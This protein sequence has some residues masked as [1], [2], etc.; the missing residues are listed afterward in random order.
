MIRYFCAHPTAAN[1]LM[2]VFLA[3]GVITLPQIN[4]ETF[5]I[6]N[7]YS[8]Q[9]QV[10]YPGATPLDVEQGICLKLEDAL[11]G[12]SFVEEKVCQ[13]RQNI[14]IMTVKMFE[15]GDFSKFL[16]D[17][18][19]AVDSISDFP[20]EAEVATVSEVGRIQNV[21]AVALT[22]DL[23]RAELKTLAEQI[24]RRL[25]RHENI[26]LVDI[27]G[28][29]DRQMLISVPNYNIRRYGLSLQDIANIVRNQNVD[30]PVG[31]V[32]TTFQEAQLR[33]SDERKN[34]T[35]LANIV[36][37]SGENGNDVLLGD[38]ATITDTFE[39][40]EDKITFN[41]KEAA[42]LMIS[43]NTTDDS[44]TV[45]NAVKEMLIKEQ[46]LLPKGVNLRLTQDATSIV[47][48]RIRLLGTNAWQGLILVFAVMW[49]FFTFRYAFWVVMGLPVSFLFSMYWL[50]LVGISINMFSMVGL[51]LSLGILM[52]DAI[53]ISESIG[54]Q[55]KKGLSPLDAS[56]EGTKLVARGV[57]SSFLTTACIFTGLI[58]IEGTI[59]QVLKV[60]PI[61]LL[62]V[63]SVSLIEAFLILPHHLNHSLTK[64]KKSEVSPF[65]LKFEKKF[66]TL[67]K[68]VSEIVEILIQYRYA[69]LGGIIAVFLISISMLASGVL[70]FSAFPN[71]EGDMIQARILMPAG[72]PLK[73]TEAVVDKLLESLEQASDTF[74]GNEK[75]KLIKA[76]IVSYN[77]NEDA[78]ESGPHLATIKVDLLTSGLRN[79]RTQ[80]FINKWREK[81]G[82]IPQS[83]A[84]S[85]KEAILGPGGKPIEIR[86][87]GD[88]FE[89]LTQASL[90]LQSWLSGYNGVENIFDDL[91]PGKPEFSITLKDGAYYLGVDASMIANQM[92]SAFQGVKVSE[93]N[94]GLN[95]FE[96]TVKLDKDS[97]NEFADFD[98]FSIVHPHTKAIIPLSSVANIEAS[99]GYARISRVNNQRTITVYSDLDINK[100]N[101]KKVLADITTRWL[102]H[103]KKTYP[104]L[105][106]TFEGEIKNA[107]TTQLS[108]MRSFIMGLFGVFILLSFQFRSYLEPF[109]V[110]VAIPLAMIGV[111]WGHLLMGLQFTMP[112]MMGF[113][114]L[115]GIVVNDSILLVEFVKKWVKTGLSVHQAAA[116]ASHDRFRAVLLTS[117]TTIAGMTPLLFETS[118]QAQIL[119]PLVTSIIFGIATSTLLV[120]FVIPCLYCVLDDFGLAKAKS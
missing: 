100:N 102:P 2:M 110:L 88:D 105:S 28:F 51:L 33:V 63:I 52:D 44:L 45:L 21:I 23:P 36:V 103:F 29:S 61:V 39:S 92:R 70:K 47:K 46:E 75:Q 104:T 106:L 31:T 13:A 55:M 108:M 25:L 112:S 109:V 30:L 64:A 119:I 32:E 15:Q 54:S 48:D 73:Q 4:R 72:T 77:E 95:T 26:P 9:I 37:L 97:R 24:K 85:F 42:I 34:V 20:H 67:T 6:I 50:H 116:K 60:I 78:Y 62:S 90:E 80:T 16:D 79:T 7:A 87:K 11:D 40:P 81:T 27:Q 93:T 113:I 18:N 57:I 10:P 96:V 12:I 115:A 14:G 22:A 101:T 1:L 94:V 107:G 82:I 53:V 120:L 69:F 49:L 43:K 98:S 19:N 5:P 17:V 86:L 41:N 118:T 76:I 65:R 68:K 59:G 91:R 74:Q 89:L 83:H 8:V 99:R 38:I 66:D 114:S 35:D 3:I 111:V 117:I 71:I 58:F 84:I 56:V